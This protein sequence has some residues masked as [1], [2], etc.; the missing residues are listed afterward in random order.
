MQRRTSP[1][2]LETRSAGTGSSLCSH[3]QGWMERESWREAQCWAL[4]HS[5]GHKASHSHQWKLNDQPAAVTVLEIWLLR[6]TLLVLLLNSSRLPLQFLPL[7]G[8][9]RRQSAEDFAAPETSAL[10]LL[11]PTHSGRSHI[12]KHQVTSFD[13]K[14]TPML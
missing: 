2:T 8:T 5:E 9:S 6:D 12:Q 7:F 10:L 11:A 13:C 1:P 3:S 4:A 14:F